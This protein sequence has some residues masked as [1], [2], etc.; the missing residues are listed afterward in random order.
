MNGVLDPNGPA[1]E[2]L[3]SIMRREC[4]RHLFRVA[5][6]LESIVWEMDFFGQLKRAYQQATGSERLADF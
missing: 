6:G 2:R 4:V 5:S 3:V 1:D